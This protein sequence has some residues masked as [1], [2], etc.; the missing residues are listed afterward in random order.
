MVQA[1]E[2]Y[3]ANIIFFKLN[4]TQKSYKKSFLGGF[5]KVHPSV[6]EFL[7]PV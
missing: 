3:I 6:M 7:S 5:V 2:V 4:V 1:A